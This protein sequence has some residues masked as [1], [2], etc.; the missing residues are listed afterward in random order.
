[1]RILSKSKD[2]THTVKLY[3]IVTHDELDH[4]FI[5]M[6]FFP[7]DLKKVFEKAACAEMS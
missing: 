5:V 2:N 7:M 4:V 1:M 6:E 3:D